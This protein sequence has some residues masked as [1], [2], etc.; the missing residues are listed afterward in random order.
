V[1]GRKR[2]ELLWDERRREGEGE[3]GRKGRAIA[4]RSECARGGNKR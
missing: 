4:R 2:G 1:S 3:E